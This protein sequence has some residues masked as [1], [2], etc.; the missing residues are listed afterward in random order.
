MSRNRPISATFSKTLKIALSE[1]ETILANRGKMSN[2]M[3]VGGCRNPVPL[4]KRLFLG[5]LR[6]RLGI[7][8]AFLL[9]PTIFLCACFNR[10]ANHLLS[11]KVSLLIKVDRFTISF[12]FIFSLISRYDLIL[13][14]KIF[15]RESLILFIL[16]KIPLLLLV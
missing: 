14:V 10:Q 4:Q 8:S 16:K 11:F 13:L 2:K 7:F 6:I 3:S 15:I 5:T 1:L 12:I 9:N